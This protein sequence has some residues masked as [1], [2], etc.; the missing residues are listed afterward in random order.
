[1][2]K[3]IKTNV[4]I[5]HKTKGF[6]KARNENRKYT[7]DIGKLEKSLSA[8]KK[9]YTSVS[10]EVENL[11]RQLEK[12]ARIIEQ[13]QRKSQA[14]GAFV[15]GL[16]Q[17]GMPGAQFIQ[18]GPGM[19]RQMA[20]MAVGRM[21]RS[22]QAGFE[23]SFTGVQGLQQFLGSIPG[24]GGFLSGQVGKLAGYSE[25][26]LN[27]QRTK[28]QAAPYISGFA[29]LQKG[30]QAGAVNRARRKRIQDLEEEQATFET[31]ETAVGKFRT[32]RAKTEEAI[33]STALRKA[34]I[35]AR[36]EAKAEEETGFLGVLKGIGKTVV[37]RIT[38][39]YAKK[40]IAPI[41]EAN[42]AAEKQIAKGTEKRAATAKRLLEQDTERKRLGE[43][44]LNRLK[45]MKRAR[46]GT[47]PLAGLAGE[48]TTL[49]G[50]NQDEALQF[51]GT[52]LEA[53][54]GTAGGQAKGFRQTAFAAKT[55]FGVQ[56]GT[57]GA[58]L[59]AGRRGGVV[60]GM[61]QSSKVFEDA[62]YRGLQLG[63]SGSEMNQYLQ[64]IAQGINQFQST[65]IQINPGSITALATDIG[66][67]GISATR[68]MT[69][70]QGMTQYIQGIGGKGVTSG[71]DLMMLRELGGYKG[72]GAEGFRAARSRLEELQ[73]GVKGKG[74]KE[75]AGSPVAGFLKNYLERVGGTQGV[76]AEM[77]QRLLG[78]MGV[79]GSVKEFDWLAAQLTG[80]GAGKEQMAGMGRFAEDQAAGLREVAAI[81]KGGGLV[82][83]A[84]KTVAARAPNLVAQVQMQNQQIAVGSKVVGVMQSLEKNA[85]NTS[86]AFANLAKGP[87]IEVSNAM[88]AVST[89]TMEVA[90]QFVDMVGSGSIISS[91]MP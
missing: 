54:G 53:G 66:T 76:K 44:E 31:G 86:T 69:M 58:F 73:V 88:N 2:P 75:L 85:L 43:E 25:Q 39:E 4:V 45:N 68:A 10:R 16:A 37:D 59:K 78:R 5:E 48:G 50:M 62:I 72:G 46:G 12:Q 81:Q 27:Y 82:G 13:Q 56:G 51:L 83:A 33:R 24:V 71:A 42:I 26:A 63:L 15:Q 65:G 67:A 89:A 17:G 70:A 36:Q 1:M 61:G 30:I 79:Q 28:L 22:A 14:K 21:G 47:N 23:G 87:L 41:I 55:L 80:A 74:A 29:D 90:R 77:L 84:R 18:R 60:G 32:A 20:G 6:D 64:Q 40:E 38:G 11:T 34:Q 52:I 8:L 7:D 57:S 35:K 3:D 49:L 9:E 19:G 91:I